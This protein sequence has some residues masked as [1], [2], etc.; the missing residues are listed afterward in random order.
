M[1]LDNYSQRI[2]HLRTLTNLSREQFEEEFGINR[3]TLKSWELGKNPI[4]EKAASQLTESLEKG[5]IICTP[6]WLIFGIGDI[7][8]RKELGIPDLS[9]HF[10]DINAAYAEA[11]HFRKM[12]KNSKVI[13]ITDK[14]MLPTYEPGDYVGGISISKDRENMNFE[15][16][17]R[18]IVT[19]KNETTF[20]GK[21]SLIRENE[22]LLCLDN[23]T[24]SHRIINFEE[25]DEIFKIVWHRK[26]LNEGSKNDN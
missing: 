8:I 15:K 11:E 3:N 6:E 18:Y 10:S 26:P 17:Y 22:L 13:A 1:K 20:V 14:N 16:N 23:S 5:G 9:E 4:T 24:C 7:S 2:R 21:P 19:L 12:N 25:I